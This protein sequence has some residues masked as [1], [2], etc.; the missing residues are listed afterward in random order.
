MPPV[1]GPVYGSF[2]DASTGSIQLGPFHF[3]GKTQL[4]IP[5]VTGPDT[6]NLSLVVRDAVSKQVWSQLA[7]PAIHQTWW[8]WRP[9]LPTGREMDVEIFAEDQGAGWGQWL[10]LGWPHAIR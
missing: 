10:A 3:D 1:E 2:P 9:D 6:H 4:A 5:V 8:A 7:P